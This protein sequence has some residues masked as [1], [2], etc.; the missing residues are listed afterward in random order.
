MVCAPAGLNSF[1]RTIMNEWLAS[2]TLSGLYS[3]VSGGRERI[4]CEDERTS[5]YMYVCVLVYIQI[6][7]SCF[8]WNR[9][10]KASLA[11]CAHSSNYS[12]IC[13]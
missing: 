3:V 13:L 7:K 9:K 2:L 5:M 10:V 1:Q 6:Y 12:N 11:F 4:H 8:F